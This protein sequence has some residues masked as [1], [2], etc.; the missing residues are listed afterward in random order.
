MEDNLFALYAYN[1]WAN[2]AV[3]EAIRPLTPEHYAQPPLPGWTSVP[4]TL[5]HIAEVT[6]LWCSLRGEPYVAL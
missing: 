6:V 5:V 4:R 3:V 2:D 1:R